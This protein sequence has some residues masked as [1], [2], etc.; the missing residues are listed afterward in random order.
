MSFISIYPEHVMLYSAHPHD[1]NWSCN[2]SY[3]DKYIVKGQTFSD[4]L[5]SSTTLLH[6]F[7]EALKIIFT[8]LQVTH[9][10]QH[11]QQCSKYV[12]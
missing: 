9:S 7:I 11:S 3:T 4:L 5:A 2:V 10:I 1:I 8:C 12:L 6:T